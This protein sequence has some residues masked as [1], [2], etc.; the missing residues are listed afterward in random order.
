MPADR[1]QV[2][3]ADWQ[4]PVSYWQ[5]EIGRVRSQLY[6]GSATVSTVPGLFGKIG[7]DASAAAQ[8]ALRARNTAGA[9]LS[10]HCHSV[11]THIVGDLGH[12]RDSEQHNQQTLTT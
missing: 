4:H 7:S 1:V 12:Y 10:A 8:E 6:T 9:A 3:D 2:N 11:H 5:S